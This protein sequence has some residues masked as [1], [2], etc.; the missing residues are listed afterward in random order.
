MQTV[1]AV[2]G[3]FAG[4]YLLLV[5]IQVYHDISTALENERDL[6][7]GDFLVINKK[8]SILGTANVTSPTFRKKEIK[9][10][11]E[12]EYVE[13]IGIFTPNRYEVYGSFTGGKQKDTLFLTSMFFESVPDEFLDV[14]A[15]KWK[16]EK[17]DSLIPIII[18]GDYVNLYNFALAPS[19]N[20]NLLS[21]K[22]IEKAR[23]ILNIT[24]GAGEKKIAYA[25]IVGYSDRLNSVLVPHDFMIHANK[26]WGTKEEREPSRIILRVKDITDERLAKFLEENNYETNQE[27]MRGSRLRFI[28]TIVVSAAS[29][30][31]LLIVF[32]ALLIFLMSFRLLI[33]RSSGHIQ[34][35]LQLGFPYQRIAKYYIGL[36]GILFGIVI[37]LTYLALFVTK[38]IFNGYLEENNLVTSGMISIWVILGS[39]AFIL[40]FFG[41][42]IAEIRRQIRALGK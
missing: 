15:E 7:G 5:S 21:K 20:L 27:K 37:A 3:A 19:Q 14:K 35:L 26:E 1:G 30:V 2:F 33:T 24:T 28:M 10:I 6:I 18:P 29:G 34:L 22:T 17:G 41:A 32:L 40:V 4:I 11:E 36:F 9:E 42:N 38:F 31:G 13:S 8:V 23:F 39:L 25:S 12:L 16:W